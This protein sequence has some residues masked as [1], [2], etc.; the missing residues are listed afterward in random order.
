M[1]AP[2][3]RVRTSR[4]AP[5]HAQ[6]GAFLLEALVGVLIFAFGF[7]KEGTPMEGVAAAILW[8]TVAFAGTLALGRTFERER[9]A[10]TLR[11]MERNQRDRE[12][13]LDRQER[14]RR[15]DAR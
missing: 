14:N 11:Q 10:D 3:M 13:R 12:R 7:V 2:T 5:A 15:R 6:S 1:T 9:Q 8:V 4:P